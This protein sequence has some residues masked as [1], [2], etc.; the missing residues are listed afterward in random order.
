ME[1]ADA[2][3]T[4]SVGQ[5]RAVIGDVRRDFS[6]C[7]FRLRSSEALR[8]GMPELAIVLAAAAVISSKGLRV[9]RGTSHV[10]RLRLVESNEVAVVD[11]SVL[12]VDASLV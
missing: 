3:G 6:M 4:P 5:L 7:L 1:V 12:D 11:A 8:L 9:S 2:W 10:H